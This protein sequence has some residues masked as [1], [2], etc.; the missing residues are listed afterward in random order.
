MK[1][2][3]ELREWAE[4]HEASPWE[5]ARIEKEDKENDEDEEE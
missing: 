3:E 2:Y 1:S 4:L 5:W